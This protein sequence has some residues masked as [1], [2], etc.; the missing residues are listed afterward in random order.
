MSEETPRLNTDLARQV[1][2]LGLEAVDHQDDEPM[3]TVEALMLGT[4]SFARNYM[5]GADLADYLRFV[6]EHVERA[7]DEAGDD[8]DDE[9]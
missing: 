2:A 7:D 8:W 4:L 1:Q 5:S 9:A 6:A 3:A